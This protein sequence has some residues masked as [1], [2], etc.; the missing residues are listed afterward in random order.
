VR[1]QVQLIAYA[2][3]LGGDLPG[4]ARVLREQL[5]GAFGGVHVLPFFTPFDGADAGFDPV[6]HTAV[7]PRLGTWDDLRQLGRDH[8]TVVD[9][10]VNHVSSASPQFQDVVAN[11]NRSRY[12]DMFLTMSSVFPNGA[13]EADLTRIYR[14]RPGLAFSPVTLGGTRRLAW[15]T[16]TPQQIDIDVH[17]PSGRE[18]LT[19]ILDALAAAGVSMVRL[20]AVGYAVKRA[21][22]TCFMIPETFEFIAELTA[23]ARER[24]IDVLVEVHSYY[25]RQVEIGRSV[26]R[27]YDFALPPLVL[28]AMYTGD[29]SAL[30]RWMCVRPRNAVTVLDTHDGIGVIDVGPDQTAVDP[31]DRPGLLSP[32]EIHALVEGIHEHT[33]GASRQATGW[34]A[35]NLDVYQVNSTYYDALGRDDRRYLAARALQFF[36]PGVPQ[37]YYVGALAGGND[38]DLLARTGVGRDINRHHYPAAEV[39]AALDRPVVQALLALCRFRN[40]FDVFDGKFEF[41]TDSSGRLRYAWRAGQGAAARHAELLVDVGTG[42]ATVEWRYGDTVRRTDDLLEK[43]PAV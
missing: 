10:I 6:D 5:A 16:F 7:D 33:G 43:P 24:G 9:L 8:D 1:N 12:A 14:P 25:Q 34:A 42:A 23:T 17:S 21:G 11:G 19:T 27:V 32:S 3:R 40:S 13:T 36:T 26:D 39:A 41:S 2:D 18:Y 28:H 37:V 15:T 30:A 38:L 20:D 22:T 4:L 31:T 35:S 29:A